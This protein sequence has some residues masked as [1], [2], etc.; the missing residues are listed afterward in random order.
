MVWLG[1]LDKISKADLFVIFDDTQ[2]KKHYFEN[3]NKIRTQDGWMWLTVPVKNQPLDTNIKDIEISYDR[4]WQKKY[5]NAIRTNYSKAPY[6]NDYF[7]K[8][9]ETINKNHK[10]L[11]DLNMEILLFFFSAF[12]INKKMI[13]A[14]ELGISKDICGSDLCL[15]ICQK[16]GAK[17]YL[18]GVSGKDYLNIPSF[19]DCKIDVVPH[20]FDHPAY[21]QQYEPFIPGM[22]AIDA[23]FNLGPE[24]KKLI[25]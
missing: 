17:T 16:A 6:F 20:E 24:A 14:S 22:S 4:E 9:E 5:L 18:A 11:I 19:K 3:R 13:K 21:K 7:P 25:S 1:L 8:I 2:F 10:Y 23:L 15:V 12:G